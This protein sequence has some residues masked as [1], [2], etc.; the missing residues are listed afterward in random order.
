MNTKNI[1]FYIAILLVASSCEDAFTTTL[2]V[3]PPP[4]TTQLVGHC[5]I[6]NEADIIA[7]SVTK[8]FGL[9]EDIS[10]QEDLIND[11]TVEIY[12]S[13]T[14]KYTLDAIDPNDIFGNVNFG[15]ELNEPFSRTDNE[16][17]LRISHP[18]YETISAK[19]TMPLIVP[20][21]SVKKSG[22]FV[23]ED[24]DEGF[25][26]DIK[27]N[28]PGG[29]ENYY[30]VQLIFVDTSSSQDYTYPIYISSSDLNVSMGI[31]YNTLLI[32]DNTFDGRS[33]T[34]TIGTYSEYD[35]MFVVWRSI[36]KEMYLYSR[37]VGQQN[38]I[39]GDPFAEPVSIFSNMENG[40]GLFGMRIEDRYPVEE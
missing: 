26:V 9:L 29:V 15:I 28:D 1:F 13:G 30:E 37:S 33:Y 25:G 5:Y 22:R 21:T 10:E 32:S 35:N 40:L 19:Q 12:E 4:H 27:F 7:A 39:E 34:L 20:V 17:E 2:K 16:Y 36:S 23:N 6:D 31:D 18:D 38:Q 3:D 11:A 24:I 14:L 8:S